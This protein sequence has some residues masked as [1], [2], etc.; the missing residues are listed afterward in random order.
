MD[1]LFETLTLI[2]TGRMERI[3]LILFGEKFWRTMVN[4]DALA[5]FGTI[6][7]DD[8]KLLNFVETAD[9]AWAIIE[10]HYRRRGMVG[11]KQFQRKW[12]PVSRPELR[13]QKALKSEPSRNP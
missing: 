1:E 12:E 2:Q 6:A 10:R 13:K 9:E 8:I 7:P 5:D 11:L 4:F 3:P